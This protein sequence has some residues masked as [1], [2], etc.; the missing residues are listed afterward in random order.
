MSET[1]RTH[2]EPK[3]V[4]AIDGPVGVGKST[5]ARRVAAAL[6]YL[7]L[8]TGAMYR[9][10]ALRALDLSE[11]ERSRPGALRTVAEAARIELP[12]PG[13]VL[14]DGEDVSEAIRT[15]RLS[16]EVARVA[17]DPGVREV[18][19]RVQ[20]EIG[21][22]QPSVLE[23]RDIGT[24][25]FPD[26]ALKIYLDA[27]PASR[28]RRRHAQ[29]RAAGTEAG[30]E[31]ILHALTERDERDRGRP[32]G[33]LRVAPGARIVDTTNLGED[34]VVQLLSDMAR[35]HPVFVGAAAATL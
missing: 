17:D 16:R 2:P 23:G 18:L 3:A 31:A 5:V 19:V 9:C 7:H 8:D 26:A 22:R 12:Q 4:L 33:A 1:R 6:G 13:V 11:R 32:V 28:A 10:V 15:E 30:I 25:V 20:R 24:V 34:L 14:L 29:L 35:D 21:L 27:S